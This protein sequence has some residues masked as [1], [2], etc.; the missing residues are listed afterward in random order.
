MKIY[1]T[2]KNYDPP[3]EHECKS[4]VYIGLSLEEAIEAVGSFQGYEREPKF[5]SDYIPT[6]APRTLPLTLNKYYTADGW[7]YSIVEFEEEE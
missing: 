5:N 4:V 1:V 6:A 7:W 2:S 3:W